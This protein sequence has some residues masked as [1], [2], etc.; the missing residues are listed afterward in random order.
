MNSV[1]PM[2]FGLGNTLG[3]VGRGY[4]LT[5]VSIDTGWRLIGISTLIFSLLM[6]GLEKVEARNTERYID[7]QVTVVK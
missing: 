3:P 4:A 6:L 5:Y 2:M 7:T 1:M